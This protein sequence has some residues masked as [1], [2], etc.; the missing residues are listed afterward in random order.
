[1]NIPWKSH[2]NPI[3]IPLKPMIIIDMIIISTWWCNHNALR[4]W[5][6][7]ALLPA[8]ALLILLAGPCFLGGRKPGEYSGD[9]DIMG[10]SWKYHGYMMY[11]YVYMYMYFYLY[12]LLFMYKWDTSSF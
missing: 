2:E 10:I 11:M 1:M 6:R 3:K 8:L 12:L 9:G 4:V 7:R 5:T